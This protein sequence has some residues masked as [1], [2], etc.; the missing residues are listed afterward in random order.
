MKNIKL[1]LAY[2]GG[3]YLGW[4]K[5]LLGPSIESAIQKTL[6][7]FL[8]HP[9]LLQAAS[10]T[11]AGVHANGQVVNFLTTKDFDPGRLKMSLNAL[12][13]DDIVVLQIDPMPFS[14]HPTLD[15]IN[16]E[17]HYFVCHGSLQLPKHRFYSWHYHYP[18]NIEKMRE[19]GDVL[20]GTHDFTSFCNTNK[21]HP[22]AHSIRTVES[23]EID[24]MNDNRLWIRVKGSNFLYKMVRNLVGTL[25]Y[26]GHQKIQSSQIPIILESKSRTAA[27]VT[28]PAHGLFLHRVNY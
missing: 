15:C 22:Y 24:K 21:D 25:V 11:D 12:L 27:G 18:L 23:I 8:Q 19:A 2:D 16:K 1:L 6:E 26:V 7:K 13:P 9:V 17:Y 3:R 10:R 4:Q 5:T 14:F 20:R 28:A